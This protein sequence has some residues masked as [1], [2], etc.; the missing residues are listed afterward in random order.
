[1]GVSP[2]VCNVLLCLSLG[3]DGVSDISMSP[4]IN[5]QH[6]REASGVVTIASFISCGFFSFRKTLMVSINNSFSPMLIC[7]KPT[8]TS[9]DWGEQ[10]KVFG[11]KFVSVFM[12]DYLEFILT[13]NLHLISQ[14]SL[15]KPSKLLKSPSLWKTHHI[16]WV[17][18]FQKSNPHLYVFTLAWKNLL[19]IILKNKMI[20]M[21][22]YDSGTT[23]D[24]LMNKHFKQIVCSIFI[25][26]I[27]FK[28]YIKYI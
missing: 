27:Y 8:K 3:C 6:T 5:V 10:L 21:N 24:I 9:R 20:L 26:L 18:S 14:T 23:D 1:M 4:A 28:L 17:I 7:E 19:Q 2:R 13:A 15:Q 11:T 16:Q 12:K 22:I 25:N